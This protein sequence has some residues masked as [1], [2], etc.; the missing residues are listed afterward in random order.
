MY[1]L[2]VY[3]VCMCAYFYVHS[4]Q[5]MSYFLCLYINFDL[6]HRVSCTLTYQ[7]TLIHRCIY[8]NKFNFNNHKTKQNIFTYRYDIVIRI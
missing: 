7:L 1:T 2:H 8:A 3:F 6:Q 5:F 4:F